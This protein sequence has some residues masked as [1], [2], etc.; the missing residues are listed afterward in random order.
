MLGG[1]DGE[2]IISNNGKGLIGGDINGLI[3]IGDR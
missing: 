2:L 1:I 3:S